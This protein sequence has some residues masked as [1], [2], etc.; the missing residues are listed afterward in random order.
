MQ[1]RDALPSLSALPVARLAPTAGP[2]ARVPV[3]AEF[4]TERAFVPVDE[5]D[6]DVSHDAAHLTD[7]FVKEWDKYLHDPTPN[8]YHVY[9]EPVWWSAS[10][11]TLWPTGRP[12]GIGPHE[13]TFVN[14]PAVGPMGTDGQGRDTN[15]SSANRLLHTFPDVDRGKTG[16]FEIA[17]PYPVHVRWFYA[18][19]DLFMDVRFTFQKRATVGILDPVM[20]QRVEAYYDILNGGS[21]W[22]T[23]DKKAGEF[24][25]AYC[26][27]VAIDFIDAG[28]RIRVC[29]QMFYSAKGDKPAHGG[30]RMYA[31]GEA[32]PVAHKL[33]LQHLIH[34][35]PYYNLGK[36][37]DGFAPGTLGQAQNLR[38]FEM[39]NV[40]S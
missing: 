28:K 13:Y 11:D 21:E 3:D 38:A 8:N 20:K 24:R 7:T 19:P 35:C 2:V 32:D 5:R 4:Y 30:G 26:A 17:A 27:L 40:F 23:R 15:R 31:Q 1:T 9:G 39:D 18:M 33:A 12:D 16:T 34:Q 6:Q 10:L 37:M 14:M 36:E 25:A 22:D 29:G